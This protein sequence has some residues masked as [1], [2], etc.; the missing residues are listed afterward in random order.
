[1]RKAELGMT[2]I[3]LLVVM[4]LVIAITGLVTVRF[5][6]SSQAQTEKQWAKSSVMLLRYLQ[7]KSIE[8]GLIHKIRLDELKQ[9]LKV[10]V[11]S[12]EPGEFEEI[13]TPYSNQWK[14][15]DRYRIRFQKGKEI[16]FF[17]DGSMTRNQLMMMEGSHERAAI[18]IQNRI[19]SFQVTYGT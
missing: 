3:E 8:E 5:I 4:A 14:K 1:M 11:E 13:K 7:F 19:G 16:Y 2:F 6:G 18:D 17:P 12:E 15:T 9:S 10:L